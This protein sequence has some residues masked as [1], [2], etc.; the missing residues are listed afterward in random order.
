[1]EHVGGEGATSLRG[2]GVG[3]LHRGGGQGRA[4]LCTPS[5]GRTVM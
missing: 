5:P 1:M 2:E 3:E 4:L